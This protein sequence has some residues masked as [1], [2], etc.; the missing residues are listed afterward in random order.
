M[1]VKT[2]LYISEKNLRTW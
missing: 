1:S 2:E